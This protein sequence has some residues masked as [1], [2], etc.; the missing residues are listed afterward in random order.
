MRKTVLQLVER[1]LDSRGILSDNSYDMLSQQSRFYGETMLSS[2]AVNSEVC[3]R[4]TSQSLGICSR[5]FT[6]CGPFNEGKQRW[7]GKILRELLMGRT[8]VRVRE[9][10]LQGLN[11]LAGLLA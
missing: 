11:L 6:Y 10:R 2:K 9:P 4:Q 5:P 8:L 1:L 7:N 3:A